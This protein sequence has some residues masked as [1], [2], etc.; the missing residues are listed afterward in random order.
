[1]ASVFIHPEK[2]HWLARFRVYGQSGE[3]WV[4]AVKSTLVEKTKPKELAQLMADR[5]EQITQEAAQ[6]YATTEPPP[7]WPERTAAGLVALSRRLQE[8]QPGKKLRWSLW[9]DLWL[10]ERRATPAARVLR[11]SVLE[12]LEQYMGN[13][14]TFFVSELTATRLEAY[15]TWLSG[16]GIPKR[17]LFVH[18]R[19]IRAC[20]HR[21]FTLGYTAENQA[22]WVTDS[23]Q[24]SP[25]S[26]P[27]TGMQDHTTS[28]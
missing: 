18:R 25:R 2:P 24:A 13:A 20:L 4:W 15:F 9:K 10:A 6:K 28:L 22:L 3:D 7:E 5:F 8:F 12:S 26:A 17:A 21:A 1:M 11:S 19:T 16:R 27:R 14:A 23:R